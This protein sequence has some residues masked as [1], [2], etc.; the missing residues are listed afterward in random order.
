VRLLAAHFLNQC[1]H[2]AAD[3]RPRVLSD[4]ALDRLLGHPWPG[5]LRQLRHEMQRATVLAGDDPEIRPEHLSPTLG[6]IPRPPFAAASDSGGGG[7]DDSGKTLHEKIEQLERREIAQ[8][9]A[10]CQRNRSHAAERLGLSRQ[11]LLKKM[12][13]YDLS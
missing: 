8:A 7:D 13:R 5:N 12:E 4:A 10:A 2:L 9:L 3:G 6:P 11:G 1:A